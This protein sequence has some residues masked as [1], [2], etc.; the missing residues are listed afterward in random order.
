MAPVTPFRDS[1]GLD[2]K[3]SLPG[4]DPKKEEPDKQDDN[5]TGAMTKNLRNQGQG[6]RI[7]GGVTDEKS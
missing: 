2:K 1:G 5:T 3:Y 6:N 4:S 7:N